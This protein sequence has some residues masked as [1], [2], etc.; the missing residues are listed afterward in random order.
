MPI[1]QKKIVVEF[2]KRINKK[3]KNNPKAVFQKSKS[4]IALFLFQIRMS[5]LIDLSSKLKKPSRLKRIRIN[6]LKARK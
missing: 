6:K 1:I 5:A 2:R 3:S 4:Q